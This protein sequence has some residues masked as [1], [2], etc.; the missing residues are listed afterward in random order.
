M[1]NFQFERFVIN[2]FCI[3]CIQNKLKIIKVSDNDLS[4]SRL[5]NETKLESD[6]FNIITLY[7]KMFQKIKHFKLNSTKNRIKKLKMV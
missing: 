5:K 6:F 4:N 3:K 7:S 1:H 2:K